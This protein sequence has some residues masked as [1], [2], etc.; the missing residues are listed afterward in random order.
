MVP[1]SSYFQNAL[2]CLKAYTEQVPSDTVANEREEEIE[3][4]EAAEEVE[5][6]SRKVE[7]GEKVLREPPETSKHVKLEVYAE[8]LKTASAQVVVENTLTEYAR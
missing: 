8:S 7:D 2:D 1:S 5:K 3:S 6:Q 4:M